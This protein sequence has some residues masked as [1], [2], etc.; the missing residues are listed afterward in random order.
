MTEDLNLLP[1]PICGGAHIEKIDTLYADWSRCKTCGSKGRNWNRRPAPAPGDHFAGGGKPIS[2]G[3]AIVPVRPTTAML[4][5]AVSF[6]LMVKLSSEYNWTQYMTDVWARM[7]GAAMAQREKSQFER[8][9]K[10]K[11]AIEECGDVL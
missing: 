2:D 6:A 3:F 11:Q 7:V 8:L 5:V 9:E 10:A 4:D 1:C